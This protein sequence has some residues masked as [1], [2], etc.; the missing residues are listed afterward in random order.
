V[1]DPKNRV[2]SAGDFDAE[3]NYIL[4]DLDETLDEIL[5]EEEEAAEAAGAAK[6]GPE[7]SEEV[8]RLQEENARLRDQ[9]VRKLAD[10]ENFRKR[11]DREKSEYFRFALADFIRD[12][13]PV[14]DNFERALGSNAEASEE[15]R[16]GIELIQKQL[17]ETLQKNGVTTVDEVGVPFDP[18]FH[19]AVVSEENPEVPNHTVVDILQKGYFLNERLIRPAMVKVAVGGPERGSPDA[20]E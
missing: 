18:T 12:L 8:A 9:Y 5:A 7:S 1:T 11:N 19:E 20:T 4:E 14:L 6:A 15:F 17:S 3:G 16:K 10:F 2:G 13:L